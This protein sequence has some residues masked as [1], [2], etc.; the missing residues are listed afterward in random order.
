MATD[1]WQ[2]TLSKEQRETAKALVARLNPFFK[3]PDPEPDLALS[4]VQLLNDEDLRVLRDWL[5]TYARAHHHHLR[6]MISNEYER[7]KLELSLRRL[8][9]KFPD[10]RLPDG[11][12]AAATNYPEDHAG[13]PKQLN[14]TVR[15]IHGKDE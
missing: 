15:R 6:R 11:W 14:L 7:R 8:R 2:T 1:N 5:Y 10:H 9:E 13:I 3:Q 12:I 4:W